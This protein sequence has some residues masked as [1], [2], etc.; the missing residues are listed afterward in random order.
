MT[1]QFYIISYGRAG[2]MT[3]H[4]VI[5]NAKIVIPESQYKDYQK[6]HGTKKLFVIPDDMDGTI[7]KKR[8]AVLDLTPEKK[9]IM[10]DDDMKK[11]FF[12]EDRR[13]LTHREIMDYSHLG[14][15]ICKDL[16][17]H[18]WGF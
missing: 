6:I 7:G 16:N 14:F 5:P 15:Q 1:F 8:N 11:I 17:S 3:T 12:I 4:K 2:T 18:Y 9:I 10:L 13:D